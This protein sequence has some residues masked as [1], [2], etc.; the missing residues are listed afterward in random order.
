MNF[1]KTS[2]IKTD[3]IGASTSPSFRRHRFCFQRRR[4]GIS[5]ES[6]NWNLPAPSGATY[7]DNA[8][9]D[10]AFEL[11]NDLC[12]DMLS[13]ALIFHIQSAVDK[14]QKTA[15]TVDTSGQ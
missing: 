12:K 9:P 1:V 8:S 5:V 10:G 11:C 4:R 14:G 13:L 6:S 2:Q 15:R 3:R 7:S